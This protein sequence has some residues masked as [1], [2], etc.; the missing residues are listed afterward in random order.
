MSLKLVGKDGY[1]VTEAGFGADIGMEKFFDIKCRAS[2]ELL[3]TYY[4]LLFI[5]LV[6]LQPNCVVLV[7]S[8]RA[9]KMHGGGPNVTSG[10]PLDPAYSQEN[11][12]LLE[13]G[14]ANL[15][16]HIENAKSFG[17]PVVVAINVFS[18][19]TRAELELVQRLC[20]ESGASDAVICSHW[21]NGGKGA[22]ELGEAVIKACASQDNNFKFL[23]PLNISL[24]VFSSC[25]VSMYILYRIRLRQ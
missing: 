23:Y 3:H 22:K 11:L 19:D 4:G 13:T 6:D 15:Q 7:A 12:S 25:T 24:K 16:K 20:K 8:V 1:V 10:Q 21:A 2:S 9:L 18:T 17:V 5:L 14:F